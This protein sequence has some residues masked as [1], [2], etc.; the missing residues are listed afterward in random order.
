MRVA[1]SVRLNQAQILF[2]NLPKPSKQVKEFNKFSNFFWPKTC[3]EFTSETWLNN[4]HT[5]ASFFVQIKNEKKCSLLFYFLPHSLALSL[6]FSFS[7]HS[8]RLFFHLS[9]LY[10]YPLHSYTHTHIN[11]LDDSSLITK[12]LFVF[13]QNRSSLELASFKAL[14]LFSFTG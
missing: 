3:F 6:S 5:L 14:S 9:I 8:L 13:T 12:S 11:T 10:V 7:S 4:L 2:L 1:E